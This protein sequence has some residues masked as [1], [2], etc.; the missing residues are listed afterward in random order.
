MS[1]GNSSDVVGH[2]PPPLSVSV[3]IHSQ[4]NCR[5]PGF[6]LS[7]FVLYKTAPL[8]LTLKL[9][10]T[11]TCYTPVFSNCWKTPAQSIKI[12]F[13]IWITHPFRIP[14]T[15]HRIQC[16]VYRTEILKTFLMAICIPLENWI[17]LE[18]WDPRFLHPRVISIFI[19]ATGTFQSLLFGVQNKMDS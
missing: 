15:V 12:P 3:C 18:Y 16:T 19:I 9:T 14:N 5:V 13:Y 11:L 4:W 1:V 17:Y 8:T 6:A 7:D 10:L 2:H